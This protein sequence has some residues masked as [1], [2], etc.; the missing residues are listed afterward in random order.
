MTP[1][2]HAHFQWKLQ[3]LDILI[4]PKQ[5]TFTKGFELFGIKPILSKLYRRSSRLSVS[6]L[7]RTPELC[8]YQCNEDSGF[9][10]YR[11]VL[12]LYLFKST[13]CICTLELKSRMS[14][15]RAISQAL[16]LCTEGLE[17]LDWR[18]GAHPC[19]LATSGG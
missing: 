9:L 10:L 11:E 2:L 7:T 1:I 4:Q 19:G 5:T 16:A 18:A 15:A 17:E 14:A 8:R 13:R 6:C 3:S 12:V